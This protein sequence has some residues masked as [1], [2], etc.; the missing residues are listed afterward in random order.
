[1]AAGMAQNLPDLRSSGY[2]FWSRFR[3]RFA[4]WKGAACGEPLHRPLDCPKQGSR[5]A[6][7]RPAEFGVIVL[8]RRFSH[9]RSRSRTAGASTGDLAM[10]AFHSFV[11]P[12]EDRRLLS[13]AASVLAGPRTAGTS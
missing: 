6:R 7:P 11:E 5:R 12:L 8:R 3:A 1:M 9:S 10:S 13:V 4:Q 2:D